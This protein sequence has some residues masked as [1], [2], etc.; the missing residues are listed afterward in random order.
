MEEL[1]TKHPLYMVSPLAAGGGIPGLW[2]L[3]FG[4]WGV[5]LRT[6]RSS[7]LHSAA[8][9]RVSGAKF[10]AGKAGAESA[11]KNPKAHQAS[12]IISMSVCLTN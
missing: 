11:N 8:I 10:P 7:R 1:L 6:G 12:G 9:A 5:G 4:P 3:P 2:T